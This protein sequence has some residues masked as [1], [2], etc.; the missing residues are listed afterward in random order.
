M[1]QSLSKRDFFDFHKLRQRSL[2]SKAGCITF[3]P[4]LLL[5]K[6][7]IFTC[8]FCESG[9]SCSLRILLKL[10]TK[11]MVCWVTKILNILN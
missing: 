1:Q 4:L 2:Y 9:V 3:S 8:H 5:R 11:Y 6:W 10:G 7:Q